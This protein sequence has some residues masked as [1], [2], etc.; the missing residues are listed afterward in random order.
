M[1]NNRIRIYE[2]FVMELE[3]Y[4]KDNK[5]DKICSNVIST[6]LRKINN[7]KEYLDE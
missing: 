1:I 3:E 7:L 5:N 2:K 6:I 4:I